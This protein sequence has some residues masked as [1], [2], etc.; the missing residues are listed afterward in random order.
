[1]YDIIIT[2]TRLKIH[3]RRYKWKIRKNI[4][5]YILS[6]NIT[7]KTNSLL[8][9]FKYFFYL[10][11]KKYIVY[12][13]RRQRTRGSIFFFFRTRKSTPS[14]SHIDYKRVLYRKTICNKDAFFCSF[15]IELTASVY[16]HNLKQTDLYGTN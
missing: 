15:K 12:T 4:T 1:M 14:T 13:R 2:Y 11:I 16:T 5:Y 6:I 7:P 3:T 9:V 10:F 8:N